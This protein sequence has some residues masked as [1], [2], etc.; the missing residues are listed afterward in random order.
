MQL[1][2]QL[3]EIGPVDM[4]ILKEYEEVRERYNFLISQKQ[5]IIT[6]IE[7]LQEAIKK[8]N[9]LTKKKI[10]RNSLSFEGKI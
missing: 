4:E 7:E 9:S 2:N 5:D 10:K 8:I 6:S 3:K 1:K